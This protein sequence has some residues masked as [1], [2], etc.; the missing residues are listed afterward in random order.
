MEYIPYVIIGLLVL[1]ALYIWNTRNRNGK[2]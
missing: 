1:A 2:H